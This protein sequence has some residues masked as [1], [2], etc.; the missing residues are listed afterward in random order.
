MKLWELNGSKFEEI[1]P[2]IAILPVGS[3]ERHGNHLPLGTDTIVPLS[4]AEEVANRRKEVIVLPPI[5]YGS[6][7]GLRKFRGTFDI[8]V[9]VLYLYVK[10]V[11]EEAV[12]NGF[13]IILVLNG[14]GG[15]TSIIRLAAREVAL[16]NDVHIVVI[17]WWRDIAE[18]TRKEL[19]KEPGHAGEDETSIVLC[20]A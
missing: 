19:F 7:R 3:I 4:L 5:W 16:K 12:R 14:H 13:K 11:L 2:K 18:E 17:D 6:C 1:S 10:N 20:I 9:E 8:D 15:N